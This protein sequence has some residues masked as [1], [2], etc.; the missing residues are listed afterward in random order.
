M[1]GSKISFELEIPWRELWSISEIRKILESAWLKD[2]NLQTANIYVGVGGVLSEHCHLG[3][4]WEFLSSLNHNCEVG[5][6]EKSLLVVPDHHMTLPNHGVNLYAKCPA[7]MYSK[8][9]L[10]NDS[11]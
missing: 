1:R 8:R 3:T 7:L 11:H 5:H 2:L 4:L 9:R 6:S 10:F